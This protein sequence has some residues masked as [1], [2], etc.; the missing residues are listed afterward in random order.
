MKEIRCIDC[1]KLLFKITEKRYI[2]IPCSRPRCRN[3]GEREVMI[4]DIQAEKIIGKRKE[5][6]KEYFTGRIILS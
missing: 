5:L 1:G 2:E 6:T 4:Y 3:K